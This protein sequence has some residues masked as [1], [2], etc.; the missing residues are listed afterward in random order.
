M[1]KD[2]AIVVFLKMIGMVIISAVIGMFSLW[3]VYLLP[4]DDMAKNVVASENTLRIQDDSE[5]LA[6]EEYWKTYDLGTNIIILHEII[7]PGSGDALQDAML[8]PTANYILRWYDDWTDVLIEFATE[9]E[10]TEVDY[11]SYA[12]Y[13]HGYLVFLKPLF[14]FMELQGIYILNG[15]IL[16]GLTIAITYLLKKRLGNYWIAYLFAVLTMNPINIVQSFQLST[17]FYAIQITMLL[18]LI[19]EKW[20]SEQILYIFL[21]DGILVAFL[22]FLTYPFLAFAIPFLTSFML[23]VKSSFKHNFVDL[24]EKG[25]SFSIGYVGMWGMKWIIATMFTKENVILDAID[26]VLHR[27]GF[28]ETGGDA[29]FM[30]IGIPQALQRN[31]MAYFNEW[32]CV[33]FVAI[34]IVTIFLILCF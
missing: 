10:Y 27:A 11:L 16:L 2:N 18:L 9:R 20:K 7:I 23:N 32:N 8:A 17:V 34:A 4:T 25:V 13:W 19:K 33:L 24:I 6:K 12:R 28:S 3:L 29:K 31:L 26:S 22:D 15:I 14:M 1:T 5:F 30:S 21:L